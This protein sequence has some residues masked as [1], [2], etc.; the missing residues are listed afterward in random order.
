MAHPAY[1]VIDLG[2]GDSGKGTIVDYLVRQTGSDLVV[3]FNGGAQAGHNVITQGG[4]HHTF[5]QFGSGTFVPGCRTYLSE[6]VSIHPIALR[7]EA[8]KLKSV[9]VED[10]MDRLLISANS[11]ITTPFHQALNCLKELSRGASRHG[12]CGVGFGETIEYSLKHPSSAYSVWMVFRPGYTEHLSKIRANLFATAQTL[13]K[14]ADRSVQDIW[15]KWW[16]ILEHEE[17]VQVIEKLFQECLN[18]IRVMGNILKREQGQRR[19]QSSY[20]PIFEGAQGVLLD[21]KWGF[22][23]YNTW[24][25]TTGANITKRFGLTPGN[26]SIHAIGVLRAFPTRHGEGPFPTYDERLTKVQSDPNNPHNQW[27]GSIRFGW[28]DTTLTQYALKACQINGFPINSLA[29]THI[30]QCGKDGAFINIKRYDRVGNTRIDVNGLLWSKDRTA[31]I[32]KVVPIN[33]NV[34]DACDIYPLGFKD[35][36]V[37]DFEAALAL[38]ITIKS[39]GPKATDK[40]SI[41]F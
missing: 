24:S 6:D 39:S 12:S 9:G 33:K 20:T 14:P 17:N 7:K 38:P 15:N 26:G 21:D 8:E 29:V 11:L 5:S 31:L 4:V 30:D 13:E 34:P 36:A 18:P 19:V 23:P 37:E 41:L 10:A 16:D 35:K 28:F 3:R 22:P 2:F 40:E 1:A 32:S 25:D 27:Q